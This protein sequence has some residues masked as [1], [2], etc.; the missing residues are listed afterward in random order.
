MILV[1]KNHYRRG[2]LRDIVGQTVVEVEKMGME[3]V[4]RHGRLIDNPSLWQRRRKEQGLP[5]V[6]V[7]DVLVFRK[8]QP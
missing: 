7:E 3:L 1:L 8:V 6:E 5:I 2:V 4:A